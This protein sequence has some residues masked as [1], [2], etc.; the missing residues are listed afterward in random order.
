MPRVTDG[1]GV[2]DS[3]S[4]LLIGYFFS[5]VKFALI[6][7]IDCNSSLLKVTQRIFFSQFFSFLGLP[8][9]L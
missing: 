2:M 5:G 3:V 7:V 4:R 6:S 8:A 9:I 1:G